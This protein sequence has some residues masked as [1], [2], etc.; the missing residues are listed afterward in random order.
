MCLRRK[1][2][3]LPTSCTSCRLNPHDQLG[4]LCVY[5][6]HKRPLRAPTKENSLVLIAEDTGGKNIEKWDQ[7][8]IWAAPTVGL[9][10]STV[11]EGILGKWGGLSLPA[12]GRTL[13]AVTQEK[14]FLFL[15]FDLF[16]IFFWIFFLFF[17]SPSHCS[18]RFYWHYGI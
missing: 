7:I 17:P 8:W 5:G 14:H 3:T 1:T 6:I 13:T 9:E 18:C 12:R 10:I 4:R 16:C 11:L 15:C 2:P